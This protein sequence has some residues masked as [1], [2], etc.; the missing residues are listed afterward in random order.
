MIKGCIGGKSNS[1]LCGFL[2]NYNFKLSSAKVAAYTLRMHFHN[3][4]SVIVL[5]SLTF[6]EK[7]AYLTSFPL[8][9]FD[10]VD[11]I[12]A[13]EFDKSGDHLATGDRGGR[14]VLF[15]RTDNIR[16]VSVTLSNNCCF[17]LL[18]YQ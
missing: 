18:C 6:K 15:E 5:T 1:S 2:L 8:F 4:D 12:S 10:A 7:V 17:V 13:I 3:Y 14:V 11:I 16:D 9:S